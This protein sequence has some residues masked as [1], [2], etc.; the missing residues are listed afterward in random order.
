MEKSIVRYMISPISSPCFPRR[1][2]KSYVRDGRHVRNKRLPICMPARLWGISPAVLAWVLFRWVHF[3]E[4]LSMF[5][6]P[7]A[8]PKQTRA[9]VCTTFCHTRSALGRSP[10]DPP[11]CHRAFACAVGFSR[12]VFPFTLCFR[13]SRTSFKHKTD[14]GPVSQ[15]TSQ[16]PP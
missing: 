5:R 12:S 2:F 7:S 1:V 8:R 15:K 9:I 10:E 6:S 16:A 3:A 13:Q 4:C 11:S 14:P